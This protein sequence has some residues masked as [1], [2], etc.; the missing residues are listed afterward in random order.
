MGKREIVQQRRKQQK[1]SN[2]LTTILIIAA[3]AV[4]VVGMV[5]LTQYK[6][7]GEVATTDRV[8]NAEKNGLSIGSADAPVQVVEFADFQCPACASYWAT[9]EPTILKDY[10]ETGKV[11]FTYSPFS[12]LGQ[13]QA[14]DESVKAAEAAYCA[15]DQDKFWEFR[16]MVYTN[17]NGENQG[18]YSKERL[19]AFAKEIE[20]DMD[21]FNSCFNSGKYSQQVQA[22]NQFASEQGATYTPSFLID[23]QIVNANELVQAIENSL[24]K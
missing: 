23:G 17:H 18:A 3:F 10:I 8:I 2:S 15:N 24:A 19:V 9:L 6:P 5:I 11:R 13:G 1:S 14:W 4:V 22:D 20:L 12:F 7:V 16:D 21:A